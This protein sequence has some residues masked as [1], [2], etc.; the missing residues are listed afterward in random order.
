MIKICLQIISISVIFSNS[1]VRTADKKVHVCW[2]RRSCV[3][4]DDFKYIYSCKNKKEFQKRKVCNSHFDRLCKNKEKVWKHCPEC[5][6]LTF[7]YT[8]DTVNNICT[9]FL[10]YKPTSGHAGSSFRSK[11]PYK[12]VSVKRLMCFRGK[13]KR[14][15]TYATQQVCTSVNDIADDG[16]GD[17]NRDKYDLL[18]SSVQSIHHHGDSVIGGRPTSRM[19]AVPSFCRL[20]KVPVLKQICFKGICKTYTTSAMQRV[21]TSVNDIADDIIE[22]LEDE[23]REENERNSY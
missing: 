19:M 14:Y 2:R 3:T 16:I 5:D 9:V 18:S 1:Q 13:C 23:Y 6:G 20:K 15:W 10:Q 7:K 4:E 8:V 22:E 11:C 12:K 21:C 17:A